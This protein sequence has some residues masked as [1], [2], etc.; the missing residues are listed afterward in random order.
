MSGWEKIL[1]RYGA[2]VT[3]HAY[4]EEEGKATLALI[5]PIRDKQRQRVASP[6]GWYKRE[7][8]LYLGSPN[9]SPEVGEGGF[10][11]CRG[12]EFEVYSARRVDLGKQS[13]HWWAILLPREEAQS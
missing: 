12:Q 3:I 8:Y 6:L 11:R 7:R 1:A 9:V 13:C 4:G 10:L 2:P 5:Q